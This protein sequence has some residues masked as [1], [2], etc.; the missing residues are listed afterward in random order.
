[1]KHLLA[2][3]LLFSFSAF[4]GD[5][6]SDRDFERNEI[7]LHRDRGETQ[8]YGGYWAKPSYRSNINVRREVESHQRTL[9]AGIASDR[10]GDS[11]GWNGVWKLDIY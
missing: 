3:L 1:M 7:R 9:D 4:A 6:Y 8:D 10:M 5:Y 11:R 2:L